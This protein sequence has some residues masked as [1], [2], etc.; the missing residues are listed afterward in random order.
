MVPHL[1]V[2]CDEHPRAVR[3]AGIILRLR[4]L[5]CSARY[6]FG[7]GLCDSWRNMGKLCI[8]Q[9][10]F[11]GSAELVVG[12]DSRHGP[13]RLHR[14]DDPGDNQ[15]ERIILFARWHLF[16]AWQEWEWYPHGVSGQLTCLQPFTG[17]PGSA[18]LRVYSC[19]HRSHHAA[20]ERYRGSPIVLPP[21]P[22]RARLYAYR[23]TCAHYDMEAWFLGS[24]AV[25]KI[26]FNCF[27]LANRAECL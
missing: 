17:L 7:L 2:V 18:S 8:Q 6:S 20:K 21:G 5:A 25:H 13:G 12:L 10:D 16:H 14:V 3:I 1:H 9:F 24:L 26:A 22:L 19:L 27:Y 11:R 4:T 23:R 15:T